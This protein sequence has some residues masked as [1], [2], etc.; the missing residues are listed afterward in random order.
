MT[1]HQAIDLAIAALDEQR[2]KFAPRYEIYMHGDMGTRI[3]D[4]A[5]IYRET[6]IAIKALTDLQNRISNDEYSPSD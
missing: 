4:D 2:Q 1:I 3:A 5:Q 6:T